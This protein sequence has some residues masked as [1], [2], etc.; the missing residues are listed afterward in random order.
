[1]S[2]RTP[3]FR[4]AR[5]FVVTLFGVGAIVVALNILIDPYWRFS[6][7]AVDGINVHKVDFA[8]RIRMV[9]ANIVCRIRPT[10]VVLGTSR[11]EVAI[12]PDYPAWNRIP[13][14]TY[15]MSMAGSGIGEIYD[16]LRHAYYASGRLKQVVIGL[17]FLMF[18]AWREAQVFGT[19]VLDFERERLI[20]DDSGS[21]LKTFLYD[22]DYFIGRKAA[23]GSWRTVT[24]QPAGP[25]L[26]E[27]FLENGMRDPANNVLPVMTAANGHRYVFANQETAYTE[28]IWRAGPQ[29]RYCFAI[30]DG[31]DTLAIFRKI[32]AFARDKGIDLRLYIAPLHA[33]MQLAIREAGLWPSFED[34][35]R[36]M[37]EILDEDGVRN[38]VEAFPLWDFSGF[39]TVTMETIPPE[40]DLKTRMKWYWEGSHYSERTGDAIIRRLLGYEGEGPEVPADFGVR[41][42]PETLAPSLRIART[43][44]RVYAALFPAEAAFIT[45]RIGEVMKGGGANC[46]APVAWLR[47]A[48]RAAAAGD[49]AAADRALARA[50]ALYRAEKQRFARLGVPYRETRFPVLREIVQAGYR[51]DQP[52]TGW[53]AHFERAEKLR[54]GGYLR[55]AAYDYGEAQRLGP[56]NVALNYLRAT[57]F[58][59]LGETRNA[60]AE[61]EAGLVLDPDNP[62]MRFLLQTARAAPPAAAAGASRGSPEAARRFE[63]E[64]RDLVGRG[65]FTAA[66][67]AY[68]A[69]IRNSI[70]N[71]ALYYLRGSARARIGDH[72]G[73]I[74]DFAE[75]LALDPANTT[76]KT[77]LRRSWAALRRVSADAASP[78]R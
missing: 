15:N 38:T 65:A 69:A 5:G 40:G 61:L 30:R 67:A 1:M 13:G 7:V 54:K 42:T 55:A 29:R 4:F 23:I 24:G 70:P 51:I 14:P 63:Q 71:T 43:G 58:I 52:M 78:V 74:E 50:D 75:G 57:I 36:R 31:V 33:R 60:I 18:N 44:A 56:P 68:G 39:N 62:T 8:N 59:E 45:E 19:E 77:L 73:A 34:W 11:V 21:C 17:D 47:N 26:Q 27:F 66:I 6:L 32:V 49:R 64:G 2:A 41:L 20:V 9:K 37:V 10:K 3:A 46:G 76:L 53:Q 16:T 35:K 72:A 48:S 28:R 12:N 25:G 22:A